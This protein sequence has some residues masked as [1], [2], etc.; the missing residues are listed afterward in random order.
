VT[1]T[2]LK[3]NVD[4]VMQEHPEAANW[5]VVSC[6]DPGSSGLGPVVIPLLITGHLT[7]EGGEMT[8]ILA[9]SPDDYREKDLSPEPR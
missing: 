5:V 4:T 3:E 6:G 2:K 7:P 1:L 9:M 8:A